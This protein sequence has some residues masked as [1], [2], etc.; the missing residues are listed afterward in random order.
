MK[1]KATTTQLDEQSKQLIKATIP[2]LQEQGTAITKRFYQLMLGD[3][4]E[5][6]HLFNQTNQRRGDQPAALANTVYAAA[7]N[8][9]QLEKIVPHVYQIAHKHRSLNVR[10]DQYPI[11]GKYLLLAMK[12]VLGE[13]ASDDIIAAWEKAYGIIADLFIQAEKK[14]YEKT[15]KQSGGWAGFRNFK[16]TQ[17]IKESDVITSFYLQPK[18]GL[19]IPDFSPGQYITI[20]AEIPSEPYTHLRQYSLS[21]SPGKDY[22]R[23]SVKREAGDSQT[24]KGIV[25]N[26][27]H[28]FVQ[29]GS[30]LPV[31]APAGDF[32]LDLNDN[33]PL[34]LISGGVGVTPMMSMLETVIQEQPAREVVFIHAAK[35]G[36]FHALKDRV[37]AISNEYDH[38]SSYTLY[39]EP[40]KEDRCDVSG[41]ISYEWLRTILPATNAAFYFCGPKGFMN[42]TYLI[43]KQLHVANTDMHYEI[44]G[45]AADIT[46]S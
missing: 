39:S 12:D 36:N 3:H 29:E 34:I 11:V 7:A 25:S 32:T 24:P 18:D 21:T 1:T 46:A 16:V 19:A 38:V 13:T 20:K 10:P 43:L 26:F 5:L 2:I 28:D 6:N 22:Y 30:I 14:L 44:F 31:S 9:D 27:L 40:E 23:I 41:Y 15:E 17:K 45:P 4:P 35:A 33:R 42:K 8:I 37:Q